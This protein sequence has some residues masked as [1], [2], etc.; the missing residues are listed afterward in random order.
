MHFI[1]EKREIGRL[2]KN[3]IFPNIYTEYADTK[4]ALPTIKVNTGVTS[5]EKKAMAAR[6][7][8]TDKGGRLDKQPAKFVMMDPDFEEKA[9]AKAQ[10]LQPVRAPAGFVPPI[11]KFGRKEESVKVLPDVSK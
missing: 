10:G 9:N 1:G 3:I 2:I 11:P 8:A 7:S 5:E 4:D 6:A